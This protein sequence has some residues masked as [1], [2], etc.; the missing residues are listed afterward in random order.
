[1]VEP[2]V[3]LAAALL[4]TR[5]LP[6]PARDVTKNERGRVL[7]V[8]G[9]GRVPGGIALTCEAALRAG[10]GKVQAGVPKS[11]AIPLGFAL[12]E[13]ATISLPESD[14]EIAGTDPL[15]GP[16]DACDAAVAGPAITAPTAAGRV[17]DRMLSARSEV[18]LVFDAMALGELEDHRQRLRARTRPAVLTPH[19]GE[20]ARLRD[21]D[22]AKIEAD[23][24]AAALEAA[25]TYNAVVVLKCDHTLIAEPGGGLYRY[26]G[27]GVGLATGGSG[28]VLA[29]IVA[30]LAARGAEALD[31]ALWAV[32]LHGEAGKRCAREIGTMGFLARE[33]LPRIP[34]LLESLTPR[35]DP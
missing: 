31:A 35:A 21:C 15:A 23:R 16:L 8:G 25:A 1:M 30:G 9:S 12:P 17:V 11:I 10:A 3:A 24:P 34:K 18:T 14:G 7:V 32:W 13:I 2:P 19:L 5:P 20:M 33:L 26:A 4:R 29:G 22:V 28:D 27:G 6:Q